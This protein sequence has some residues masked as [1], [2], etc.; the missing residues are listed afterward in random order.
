MWSFRVDAEVE[1]FLREIRT[2]M[3]LKFNISNADAVEKINS[4]WKSRDAILKDDLIF[5]EES[6]YWV[7]TIFFGKGSGWWLSDEDLKEHLQE[8]EN[9]GFDVNGYRRLFAKYKRR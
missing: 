9:L 5:H 4:Y 7:N 6:D 8:L 3:V 1:K 2:N